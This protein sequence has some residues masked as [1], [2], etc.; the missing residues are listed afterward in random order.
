VLRAFVFDLTSRRRVSDTRSFIPPEF[1]AALPQSDKLQQFR[2]DPAAF[3][4]A[5][6]RPTFAADAP[7][8]PDCD[9]LVLVD[10]ELMPKRRHSRPKSGP[11]AWWVTQGCASA[12]AGDLV[13]DAFYRTSDFGDILLPGERRPKKWPWKAKFSARPLDPAVPE[14]RG[15]FRSEERPFFALAWRNDAV[16][17]V[18]L[19][20][21]AGSVVQKQRRGAVLRVTRGDDALPVL[22]GRAEARTHCWADACGADSPDCF[23]VQ[24]PWETADN[25]AVAVDGFAVGVD[26]EDVRL[27]SV[28]IPLVKDGVFQESAQRQFPVIGPKKGTVAVV[29][30]ELYS[31]VYTESKAVSAILQGDFS[32]GLPLEYG[33]LADKLL[34]VLDVVLDAISSGNR[35]AFKTLLSIVDVFPVS[36]ADSR[37]GPTGC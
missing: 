24:L 36:S 31:S 7:E 12:P 26:Q 33:A 22:S 27:G 37:A 5:V 19:P 15:L 25:L 35:F 34:P 11:S 32:G 13:F 4:V 16:L 20:S 17:R 1:L 8:T 23:P 21:G 3:S 2:K 30:W 14:V 28:A 29:E 10:R 6:S 9:G 18:R